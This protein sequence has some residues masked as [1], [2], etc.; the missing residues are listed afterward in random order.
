[1]P[2]IGSS[3][4]QN[5]LL[6]LFVDLK[7]QDVDHFL[8]LHMITLENYHVQSVLSDVDIDTEQNIT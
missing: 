1:M 2:V 5:G 7:R 3:A 4:D 8:V 6:F